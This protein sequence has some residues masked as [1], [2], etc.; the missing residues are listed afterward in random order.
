MNKEVIVS[1]IY[2]SQG[3]EYAKYKFVSPQIDGAVYVPVDDLKGV[4]SQICRYIDEGFRIKA[5]FSMESFLGEAVSAIFEET[6]DNFIEGMINGDYTLSGES[7]NV[8]WSEYVVKPPPEYK[9]EEIAG[10]RNRTKVSMRVFSNVIGVSERTIESWEQGRRH[11]TL[12]ARRIIQMWDVDPLFPARFGMVYPSK[13]GIAAVADRKAGRGE[14]YMD[15]QEIVD[16]F[17]RLYPRDG[18]KPL[19]RWEYNFLKSAWVSYLDGLFQE[20][21]IDAKRAGDLTPPFKMGAGKT[22][23]NS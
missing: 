19:K 22:K 12:M 8:K 21:K 17:R 15:E 20:G 7:H 4:L 16:G 11:P 2:K 1:K 5:E 23:M 14:R 9:P 3:K 10:I 6:Q 13:S 18:N